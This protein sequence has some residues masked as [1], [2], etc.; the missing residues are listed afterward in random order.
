M[1]HLF[2]NEPSSWT[3]IILS[4]LSKLTF[5][6][7]RPGSFPTKTHHL[8][9]TPQATYIIASKPLQPWVS[10]A[11]ESISQPWKN[12]EK[13]WN[14]SLQQTLVVWV[15][16]QVVQLFLKQSFLRLGGTKC[17]TL[18]RSVTSSPLAPEQ[19]TLPRY[20]SGD[21]DPRPNGWELE[22]WEVG[23]WNWWVFLGAYIPSHI[24]NPP[25]LYSLLSRWM[26]CM[27]HPELFAGLCVECSGW[28]MWWWYYFM[29]CNFVR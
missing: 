25:N 16:W 23:S 12:H 18:H 6:Y 1:K 14:T 15:E 28:I 4:I 9:Y 27:L 21:L 26:V 13:P 20:S 29:W 5:S 17:W 2:K 19:Q 10:N 7:R 8:R 24:S 3:N 22:S 11:I